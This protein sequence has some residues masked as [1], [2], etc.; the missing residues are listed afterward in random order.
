MIA[1]LVPVKDLPSSK[2]RLRPA[3]GDDARPL[4]LAMLGDVL[5]ALMGVAQLARVAVVTPDRDVAEAARGAGAEALLRPDPGLNAAVDGAAAELAANTADGLLVVQGDVPGVRAQQVAEL[6][7]A[8]FERG[9]VLAP[10]SDGGTSAL[11]R[12]P[13][14]V[15]AA[16]FGPASAKVHR[17]LASR[18]G[19]PFREL[20]LPSLAI[21]VDDRDD[22]EALLRSDAAAP[23]TRALL[24]ELDWDAGG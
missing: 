18:A 19:V 2:S 3:L 10:S 7:A 12:V 20:A 5:E 1:A 9:V 15:I 23:R 17:E 13:A 14:D 6:L 21:D 24:R 4:T 8:A 11:V 22:L 16:G